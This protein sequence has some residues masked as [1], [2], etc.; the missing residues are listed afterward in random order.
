MRINNN[1]QAAIWIHRSRAF[2][3]DS[4]YV[5]SILP[6]QYAFYFKIF[7]PLIFENEETGQSKK[8]SYEQL[9]TLVKK[10][11]ED[12]FC[13]NSLPSF[14]MPFIASSS[15]EDYKVFEQLIS[16]LGPETNTIFHGIGEENVPEEF[17]EPWV[18][19]GTLAELPQVVSA[20]NGNTKIELVHFPNYIFPQNQSWCIGKMIPKSGLFLMGCNE[21]VAQKLRDQTEIEVVEIS[22]A[23]KYYE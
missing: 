11:F 1:I 20:L 21:T 13:Q 12:H 5:K 22:L 8:V 19:N 3:E 18:V 15:V 23:A 10:P 2:E 17:A 7:L 14:L 6:D 9:S 4:N 16:L